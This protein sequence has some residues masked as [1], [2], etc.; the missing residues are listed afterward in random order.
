MRLSCSGLGVVF[1]SH[2]GDFQAL[3]NVTFQTREGEFLAIV[4]PSGCGKTTLL[5]ALAGLIVPQQGV[6]T[7]IAARDENQRMLLVF[8]ENNLFPWMTILENAAF[9]LEMAGIGK[10]DRNA[11]ARESL[12]RAGIEGWDNHYPAQLS[13]GMKQRVAVIRSFLSD[14]SLLLMDEPFSALDVQT[15]LTSQQELLALWE[16]S[17]RSV[18]FVTHDVEEAILL[19]DRVL[20]LGDRPGTLVASF[21]VAFRRP[22]HASLTLD[23]EFLS[24]KRKI[25]AELGLLDRKAVAV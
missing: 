6:V 5:R 22:R 8:Q 13:L 4:G 19:S 20:V 9:G 14:P 3:S 12:R 25:W 17:H 11:R 10:A 1:S 2:A 15:R 7:R 16:Q 18:V 21:P 24:L 23:E